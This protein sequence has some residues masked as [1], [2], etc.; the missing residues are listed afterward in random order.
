[1]ISV[2]FN[3]RH[4]ADSEVRGLTRYTVELLR[5]LS[6]LDSVRLVL[7]TD[8]D[9]QPAHLDGVNAEV[10]V[11]GAARELLWE[12][13]ALPRQIRHCGVDVFH[14]PA[15][16]GLSLAKV[17]PTV[18][19]VHDSYERTHWRTL[20]PDKKRKLRYW[21]H[22]AINYFLSDAVITVSDT[23]RKKL[24]SL[25]IAPEKKLTRVY[26]GVSRRFCLHGNGEDQRTISRYGIRPPYVLYVGGYDSRK[27]VDG[28]V[29]GF[30][31]SNLE[32]FQLVV[33]ARKSR[34]FTERLSAW[35][36]LAH[37]GQIHFLE[38]PDHELPRF[39]RSA[40]FFVLPSL[41]ESFGL[42]LLEAMACGTPVICSNRESMPEI[43]S[44]A[45]LCFDP[46]DEAALPTAMHRLGTDA[47]LRTTLR[48]KGLR[49]AEG[50]SWDETARQTF[51]VYEKLARGVRD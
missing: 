3:A 43:L 49:R 5:S 25:R 28:L 14:A 32:D 41:W 30:D 42:Q 50:F 24:I 45:G 19:T 23:T 9:L 22:E 13:W 21:I 47:N 7:F 15:D 18:V 2:G 33:I 29:R 8:R 48:N 20:M 4:L 10:V 37:F 11:F 39:Y 44:D 35:R 40:T 1:M 38:V 17:C 12:N 31:R 34:R 36:Q 16:R 51:C 46:A 26:N 27:N 6:R